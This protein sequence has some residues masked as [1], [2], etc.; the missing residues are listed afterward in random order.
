MA[1]GGAVTACAVALRN[2]LVGDVLPLTSD[3]EGLSHER[4]VRQL[5][6]RVQEYVLPLKAC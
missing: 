1:E 6:G 4:L 3:G 2:L 5:K